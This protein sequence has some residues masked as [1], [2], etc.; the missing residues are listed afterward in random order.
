MAGRELCQ[1]FSPNKVV[2]VL[3]VHGG[4]GGTAECSAMVTSMH[5]FVFLINK[6]TVINKVL[7]IDRVQVGGVWYY[8]DF[9]IEPS[10]G[11]DRPRGERKHSEKLLQAAWSTQCTELNA[12]YL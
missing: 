7:P 10:Q 2:V 5:R 6:N 3:Q 11:Q 8:L 1:N 9:S 12:V 4:G